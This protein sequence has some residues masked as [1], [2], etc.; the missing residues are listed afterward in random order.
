MANVTFEHVTKQFGHVT[1]VRDLS[2]EIGDREFLALLGPSGCGKSTTLNMLAGLEDVA[3]GRI[4]IDGRVVNDVSP[5]DRDVA[6][7]F[8]S[9]ALYPHMSVYD[10]MAFPLKA[11]THPLTQ[12]EIDQRVRGSAQKL[13]LGDLLSRLPRELSGGQRQR[14]ALGRALVR[15]PKV[16]LMDE[17]LSN[18]DARLRLIMRAELKQLHEEIHATVIYVTHD[19]A[20]AMTLATRIA[21]M[22][23]G[24]LQQVAS[25]EEAYSHP[26][27]M[28]VARFIGERE[29]NF[30]E[31]R[32]V[33]R[34]GRLV[35][36]M[37]DGIFHPLDGVP[38]G[39]SLL[40]QRGNVILGIRAEDV[41]IS[42]AGGPGAVGAL[43]DLL[44]PMGSHT[45]VHI[46]LGAQRLVSKVGPDLR[47]RPHQQVGIRFEKSKILFFDQVT[48][49]RI[50]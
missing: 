45:F 23:D 16:F 35:Y 11:R 36:E 46:R 9:Y 20:E 41:Q 19:Q 42:E 26:A 12:G 43:V 2:L 25:P 10:N 29:M 33:L 47:L 48:E 49:K 38:A 39:V 32:P 13:Q 1:V 17:P 34:E 6:M 18:L 28:F 22:R 40:G 50:E 37:A 3:E 4:L 27:T 31:G 44:E 8:Q 7:V 21:I 30:L 14:V 24:A 15:Q 5:R